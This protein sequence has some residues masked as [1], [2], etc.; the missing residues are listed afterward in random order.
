MKIYSVIFEGVCPVGNGLIIAAP[1]AETCKEIA[2]QTITHTP[3][4]SIQEVDI[5]SPCVV[6]YDSGDY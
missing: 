6:Y 3:D 4:F 5:S 2:S 1:D